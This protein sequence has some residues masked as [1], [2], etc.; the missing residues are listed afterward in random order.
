MVMDLLFFHSSFY[1]TFYKKKH[2]PIL[3]SFE[4]FR[5]LDF[6]SF[7]VPVD[8]LDQIE[9]LRRVS[10]LPRM[11]S[12]GRAQSNAFQWINVDENSIISERSESAPDWDVEPPE[13]A[14][15]SHGCQRPSPVEW[16][17]LGR[18]SFE[19]WP[20]LGHLSRHIRLLW[21]DLSS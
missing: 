21:I 15:A 16:C 19:T 1:I 4:L 5:L 17:V 18:Y 3:N 9:K 10:L 7:E 13:D 12:G 20:L 6:V 2:L 8:R 14:P 11:A